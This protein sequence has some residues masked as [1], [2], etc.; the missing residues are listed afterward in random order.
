MSDSLVS[1]RLRMLL[2]AAGCAAVLGLAAC[3]GDDDSSTSTAATVPTG[4]TGAE[5][6]DSGSTTGD[7]GDLSSGDISELR[8]AFNQQLMQV[9]TGQEGLTQSQAECAIKELEN[10]VSDQELADALQEAAQSGEPPQD[11]IDAGFDAGQTCANQETTRTESVSRAAG[12]CAGR[13]RCAT[14]RPE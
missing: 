5:S 7:V 10:S 8:D 12:H 3:G 1:T 11:L 13:F 9:L 4:A 2:L 14:G 6:T